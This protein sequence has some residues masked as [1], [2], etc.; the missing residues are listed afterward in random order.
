MREQLQCA[1]GTWRSLCSSGPVAASV[2]GR[3]GLARRAPAPVRVLPREFALALDT[4]VGM[5]E[6]VR[7]NARR[8]CTFGTLM[9]GL[10]GCIDA[11]LAARTLLK[12]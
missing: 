5:H 12:R 9:H 3:W 1:T 10:Q 4:W 6:D 11:A 8:R 7:A 2:C